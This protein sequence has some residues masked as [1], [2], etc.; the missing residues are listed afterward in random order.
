MRPACTR[1]PILGK[2]LQGLCYGRPGAGSD[3]RLDSVAT[4]RTTLVF[5][6]RPF[7]T[8]VF[9]MCEFL[10]GVALTLHKSTLR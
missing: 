8:S 7:F 6:F 2:V 5:V 1:Q 4:T 9:R 3:L 10:G